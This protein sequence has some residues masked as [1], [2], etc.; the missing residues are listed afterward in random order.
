MDIINLGEGLKLS[1]VS[2][3][4]VHLVNA[5]T[6]TEILDA[7]T[8]KLESLKEELSKVD[9]IIIDLIKEKPLE[10]TNRVHILD[11]F[12][13]M[14]PIK[15]FLTIVQDI[16]PRHKLLLHEVYYFQ[17]QLPD[18]EKWKKYNKELNEQYEKLKQ[19]FEYEIETILMKDIE[20]L[21][22]DSYF[23]KFYKN[24]FND[25]D[26]T[27]E[28]FKVQ[29]WHEDFLRRTWDSVLEFHGG[30]ITKFKSMTHLEW[31]Q[32][33]FWSN[34]TNP[35]SGKTVKRVPKLKKGATYEVLPTFIKNDFN[36]RII[37]NFYGSND[38][39]ISSQKVEDGNSLITV[40]ENYNYY[41]MGIRLLGSGEAIFEYI[42]IRRYRQKGFVSSF[43]QI[44]YFD[45]SEP[46]TYQFTKAPKANHLVICFSGVKVS[47]AEYEFLGVLRNVSVHK[48]YFLDDY[49]TTGS[50]YQGRNKSQALQEN[51]IKIINRYAEMY[52]IPRENII[53]LG[54]SKG[55]G[56]ALYYG[57]K[58]GA[59]VIL[60][61]GPTLRWGKRLNQ[62]SQWPASAL[63][64]IVGEPT[65]ENVEYLDN[66]IINAIQSAPSYPKIYFMLIEKD[67]L[68][69][70]YFDDFR[71]TLEEKQI[72]YSIDWKDGEGHN[73]L[74][75][76][77]GGWAKGKIQHD[78]LSR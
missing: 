17:S 46:V 70:P 34:Y 73:D 4:N 43:D 58:I 12:T 20:N 65:I 9:Y 77:V 44:E 7:E 28:V 59:G 51:I 26:K 15:K 75:K 47:R 27:Q 52:N 33:A 50:F 56:V 62:N 45:N 49:A 8:E 74:I 60:A 31:H 61:S 64:Y 71:K 78:I 55:G 1:E 2:N 38:K 32:L 30:Y 16:V 35:I 14:Q 10:P 66:M 42:K 18:N 63:N 68:T 76:H 21:D 3:K 37:F 48:L 29:L 13:R 36:T 53:T 11:F 41:R 23:I 19:F 25:Y 67:S 54:N 24:L 72:S 40:P 57:F 22:I 69:Q 39:V 6:I 5:Y